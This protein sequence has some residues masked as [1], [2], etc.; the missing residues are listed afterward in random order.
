MCSR[1][2]S[3]MFLVP[4][5]PLEQHTAITAIAATGEVHAPF[6]EVL[7]LWFQRG[8]ADRNLQKDWW[9]NFSSC[10]FSYTAPLGVS[11]HEEW[12]SLVKCERKVS[13]GVYTLIAI[14]ASTSEAIFTWCSMTAT[15]ALQP[16]MT[17][18]PDMSKA[19]RN[20]GPF[21]VSRAERK[22]AAVERRYSGGWRRVPAIDSPRC[23]ESD[24]VGHS[25]T[26][27]V[28]VRAGDGEKKNMKN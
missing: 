5:L 24:R 20:P 26:I 3:C 15:D 10:G 8:I 19:S 4:L 12:M 17:E 18:W 9:L 6:F 1:S 23:S 7:I 14:S 16:C 27:A 11:F 25:T 2:T 21:R 28:S 13:D 22:C